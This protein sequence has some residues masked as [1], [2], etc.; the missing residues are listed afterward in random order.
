MEAP[1]APIPIKWTIEIGSVDKAPI[2]IVG[3]HI[4]QV[5]ITTCPISTFNISIAIDVEEIVEIDLIDS[6]SLHIVKPQRVCHFVG[7]EQSFVSCLFVSHGICREC[8]GEG[9]KK[10]KNIPSHNC[11]LFMLYIR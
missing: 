11:E 10:C 9:C 2:L 7:E 5:G 3:K 6:L 8:N 4:S 1:N